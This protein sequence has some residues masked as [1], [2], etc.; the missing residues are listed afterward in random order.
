MGK[1]KKYKSTVLGLALLIFAGLLLYKGVTTDY[2]IL[3]SI[4]FSGLMLFFTG[5]AYIE[6][7]EKAVFGKVLFKNDVDKKEDGF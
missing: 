7:L 1:I 6:K 5:D 2:W 3:G 4:G